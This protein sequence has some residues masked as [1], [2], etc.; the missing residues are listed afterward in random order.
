MRRA[1]YCCPTA[2]IK[3]IGKKFAFLY[4]H[5]YLE[6]LIAGIMV[7]CNFVSQNYYNLFV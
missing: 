2:I 3:N 6:P 5:L 4:V 7:K 1:A